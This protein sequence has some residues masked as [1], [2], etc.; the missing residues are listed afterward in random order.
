MLSNF[1]GCIFVS[2]TQREIREDLI[3]PGKVMLSL[4]CNSDGSSFLSGL[5]SAQNPTF[6]ALISEQ[7]PTVAATGEGRYCP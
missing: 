4:S 6:S 2:S 1:H 5:L 3:I 7:N